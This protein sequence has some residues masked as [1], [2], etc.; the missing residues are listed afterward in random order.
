MSPIRPPIGAG[1]VT[2]ARQSARPETGT[3]ANASHGDSMARR[4]GIRRE[5]HEFEPRFRNWTRG[6]LMTI[7]SDTQNDRRRFLLGAALTSGAAVF[8]A[9]A[10]GALTS[11]DTG[12]PYRNTDAAGNSTSKGYRLTPHIEAY[13]RSTRG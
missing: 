10:R 6:M 2:A 5:I 4:R 11:D 9:A 13:Y 3:R 7:F 8:V 12:R 1:R